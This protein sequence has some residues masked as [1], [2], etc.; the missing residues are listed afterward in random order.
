MFQQTFSNNPDCNGGDN[1]NGGA[2]Y[3]NE[4]SSKEKDERIE[5]QIKNAKQNKYNNS[6]LTF[7]LLIDRCIEI[8]DKKEPP[9]CFQEIAEAFELDWK[10]RRY[11][12]YIGWDVLGTIGEL[13]KE[14]E[15]KQ[16]N[17]KIPCVNASVVTKWERDHGNKWFCNGGIKDPAWCCYPPYTSKEGEDDRE[18]IL[19]LCKIVKNA[20]KDKSNDKIEN[21]K[22]T[23]YGLLKDK[24][25][26]EKN[27]SLKDKKGLDEVYKNCKEKEENMTYEKINKLKN[28]E[29][30]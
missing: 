4:L 7:C 12:Y 28:D 6:Y 5:T 18:F 26:K 21:W 19:T 23:Y 29:K 25:L 10:G 1:D 15:N 20:S 8:A 14:N 22:N 3:N 16:N 24:L 13:V 17:E 9:Y 27:V 11:L 2:A 30:I